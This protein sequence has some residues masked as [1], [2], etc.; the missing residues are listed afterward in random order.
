MCFRGIAD[1]VWATFMCPLMSLCSPL[2]LAMDMSKLELVNDD[3]VSLSI[4]SVYLLPM[5]F[6]PEPSFV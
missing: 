4:I 6:S 2:S 5:M 1:D 3:G